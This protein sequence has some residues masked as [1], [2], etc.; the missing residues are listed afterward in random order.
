LIQ[1]QPFFESGNNVRLSAGFI[2]PPMEEQI[3]GEQSLLGFLKQKTSF[4]AMWNMWSSEKTETMST[5]AES[6]VVVHCSSRTDRKVVDADVCP[7]KTAQGRCIWCG[8]QPLIEC[9]AFISFKMAETDPAKF[10]RIDD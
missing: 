10:L 5:C 1:H 4:P 9:A 3:R 6:L 8:V 7:N 2:V